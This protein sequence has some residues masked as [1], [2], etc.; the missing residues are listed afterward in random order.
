VHQIGSIYKRL[1]NDA[2]STN[3]KFYIY[4]SI[5]IRIVTAIFILRNLTT[6]LL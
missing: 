6:L 2:R 3:L 5:Q 1:H 4:I